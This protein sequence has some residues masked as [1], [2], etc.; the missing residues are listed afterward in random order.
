[1]NPARPRTKSNFDPNLRF[2]DNEFLDVDSSALI[3]NS[4]NETIRPSRPD[5]LYLVPILVL[6]SDTANSW[7]QKSNLL[8]FGRLSQA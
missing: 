6:K 1:M 5:R 8:I 7:S 3:V 4:S 2:K